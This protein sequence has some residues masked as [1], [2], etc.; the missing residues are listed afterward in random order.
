MGVRRCSAPEL[1][2]TDKPW[3]LPAAN[4]SQLPQRAPWNETIATLT[5]LCKTGKC[6]GNGAVALWWPGSELS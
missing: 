3:A 2:H 4:G 6:K 5:H 1:G